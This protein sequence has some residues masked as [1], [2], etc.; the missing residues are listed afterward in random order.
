MKSVAKLLRSL[1]VETPV[2]SVMYISYFVL[3]ILSATVIMSTMDSSPET[4]ITA[5]SETPGTPQMTN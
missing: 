1:N 3:L 5:S 4:N 2:L